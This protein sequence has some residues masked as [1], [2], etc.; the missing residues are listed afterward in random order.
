M[1]FKKDLQAWA[2]IS[3]VGANTFLIECRYWHRPFCG[4]RLCEAR[5][6][7]VIC[8]KGRSTEIMAK[9]PVHIILNPRTALLGVA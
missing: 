5:G 3:E 9:I 4:K 6:F 2:L 7:K 8:D 1:V